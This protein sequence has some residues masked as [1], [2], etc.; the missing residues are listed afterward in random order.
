[1]WAWEW[2]AQESKT[3]YDVCKND[4]RIH[5][6]NNSN[7]SSND[8]LSRRIPNS[9]CSFVFSF[10]HFLVVIALFNWSGCRQPEQVG[11]WAWGCSAMALDLHGQRRSTTLITFTLWFDELNGNEMRTQKMGMCSRLTLLSA[12]TVGTTA[13][14]KHMHLHTHTPT[15]HIF[16]TLCTHVK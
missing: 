12:H 10:F 7:N 6:N 8:V 9:P 15:N 2:E 5:N 4:L 16:D 13:I 14:H 3:H 1:M 11:Q